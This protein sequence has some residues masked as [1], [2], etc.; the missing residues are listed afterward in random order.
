MRIAIVGGVATGMSAA[1]KL[2]RLDKDSEIIVFEKGTETSYGAC[3][4]PYYISGANN[5]LDLMRIR[6]KEDFAKQN[7]DIRFNNEVVDVQ[8]DLKKLII[9]DLVSQK[10]IEEKYDKLIVASG[11]S[12]IIPPIDGIRKGLKNIFTVKTLSDGERIKDYLARNDV[13]NVVIAGAGYIGLEMVEACYDLGKKVTLIEM[14]D[15]LLNSVDKEIANIIHE[16]LTEKNIDVRLSER[17]E[18]VVSESD[19]VTKVAT[20]KG[21]VKADVLILATGARPNTSF[22]SSTGISLAGNGA[23]IVN[24]K[25]ETSIKGIYAGGDCSLINHKLLQKDRY[26]PLGTNANKQGKLIAENIAGGDKEF[27]G[28][29]GTA[30]IKI[31]DLEVARTGLSEKEAEDNGI[32]Y[33]SVFV[34][35]PIHAPY[36]PG[37]SDLSIKL[38]YDPDTKVIIGAQI[39]GKKGAALRVNMLAIMIDAKYTAD[40]VMN[41]DLLYAPPFSY[42]WDAVQI[43]AGQ[44]R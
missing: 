27:P 34:N 30:A 28:A 13:N 35:A 39:A 24:K 1:S 19:Y 31:I 7:I 3:G 4:L 29:L 40:Q 17:I 37:N 12:P 10:K 32:K 14:Q 25:M 44:I 41:L 18:Q 20:N 43:A 9:N 42:V 2:R 16:N 15:N 38:L 11:A 36:Y 6:K 5:D 22:L 21:S 26:L 23:V 8:V 33:R